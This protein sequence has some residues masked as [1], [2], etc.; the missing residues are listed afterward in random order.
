MSPTIHP[1]RCIVRFGIRS[2]FIFILVVAAVLPLLLGLVVVGVLGY[3]R[4][5]QQRGELFKTMAMHLGD[6]LGRV[7]RDQVGRL[8][9]WTQFADV[10]Q[11]IA[12][13][14]QMNLFASESGTP[15]DVQEIEHQWPA[16]TPDNPLLSNILHNTLSAHLAAFQKI[17]P[18]FVELFV[19]DRQGRLLAASNKTTDFWQADEEWW[20]RCRT[21]G[22]GQLW[23][24]GIHYDDS[25]GVFSLDISFAIEAMDAPGDVAG[26]IKGVLNISPLLQSIPP[27]HA[28]ERPYRHVVLY[29]GRILVRLFGESPEPLTEQ[30]APSFM[31][32]MEDQ[33]GWSVDCISGDLRELIGYAPVSLDQAGSQAV[34]MRGITP[35]Y[36]LVH[37]DIHHVM[38]PVYRLL[39][40]LALFGFLIVTGFGFAGLYIAT[41]KI[42]APLHVLKT[43]AHSIADTARLTGFHPAGTMPNRLS[44]DAMIDRVDQIN[45]GDEIQS[46]AGDF[47]LM[48]RRVMNYHVQLEEELARKTEAIQEDLVLAREFQES[49]LPSDY[50]LIPEWNTPSCLSLQ[51]HH[52]YKPT[53]SV[54]GDFF[55]IEKLSDHK[56]SIFIA[57]VTGH[58]ARAALVTAILRTLVR[59]ISARADDPAHF[60]DLMNKQ[61]YAI[62]PQRLDIIFAT[63]FYLVLDVKER[64]ARYSTAGHPSALLIDRSNNRVVS[65]IPDG[66]GGP[67]LGLMEKATYQSFERVL[68]DRDAFLLFTDGI[69]EA[70]NPRGEEF[71]WDRLIACAT[72]N[73][74]HSISRLITEVMDET[75]RFMDTEMSP[76]D[77]CLVAVEVNEIKREPARS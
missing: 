8:H 50:P 48:A 42:I 74:H 22:P 29:D 31:L 20:T 16:L 63:A 36:I 52:I 25:A 66:A 45:T 68:H 57:D 1:R 13:V 4:Y 67:A 49:L 19:T 41:R 28:G 12:G 26:V 75:S 24:E 7:T 77:L 65:L 23:V 43:A 47:S 70:P 15:R 11:K 72:R 5:E 46:L 58:G 62:M 73:N 18:L 37:D 71:G 14:E 33:A 38:R 44:A 53:L 40:H 60:L 17:H 6:G 55:H 32:A 21:D 51:F 27:S 59:E 30:F 3:Q 9:D 10:A 69:I 76:D 54:G 35:V 34:D 56:A 2:K 61:F 39:R 64:A